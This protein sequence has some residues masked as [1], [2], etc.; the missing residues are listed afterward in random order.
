MA[1]HK[2]KTRDLGRLQVGP[3][4]PGT[5]NRDPKMSRWDPE[6]GTR[7]PKILKWDSGPGTH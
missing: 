3:R 4:K 5:G 6:P 2:S 7:E 1:Y